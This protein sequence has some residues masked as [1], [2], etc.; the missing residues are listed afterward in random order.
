MKSVVTYVGPAA[1]SFAE[2]KVM[3]LFGP[4]APQA[5]RDV[6]IIHE[7]ETQPTGLLCSGQMIAF[8]DVVY[9]IERVGSDAARNLQEL[10]HISVYFTAPPENV[11]PGAVYV[12]P[13]MAPSVRLG[14]IVEIR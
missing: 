9:Q 7:F 4:S 2:D 11:L 5:L 1:H 3:I 6:A 12:T 8:D 13:Y 10:G 14:S